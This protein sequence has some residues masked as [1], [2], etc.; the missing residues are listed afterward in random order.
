VLAARE[1]LGEERNQSRGESERTNTA[2]SFARLGALAAVDALWALVNRGA[3]SGRLVVV[4]L[5]FF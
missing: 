1:A 4:L 2:L 5:P 3:A